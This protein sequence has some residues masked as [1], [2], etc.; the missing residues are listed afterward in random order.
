MKKTILTIVAVLSLAIG[1][2]QGTYE[3][4]KSHPSNYIN[5][6]STDDSISLRKEI[7]SLGKEIEK[8]EK[9]ISLKRIN[10]NGQDILPYVISMHYATIEGIVLMSELGSI[11]GG[12]PVL[13]NEIFLLL[14][15][16]KELKQKRIDIH[17]FFKELKDLEYWAKKEKAKIEKEIK[18]KE[19][20]EIFLSFP[21]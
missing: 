8:T 21:K 2:A 11:Q 13:E 12:N 16:R 10:K 3:R 1:F 14:E 5:G 18:R 4:L 7:D 19:L 15:K 20:M 17:L 9:L 6:I